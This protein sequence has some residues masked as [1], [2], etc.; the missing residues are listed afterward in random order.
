MQELFLGK[1]I[2][3][4]F[5]VFREGLSSIS[6]L[7]YSVF[8]IWPQQKREGEREVQR[9]KR[10]VEVGRVSLLLCVIN[11]PTRRLS[12]FPALCC[13]REAPRFIIHQDKAYEL[14]M[15]GRV[16]EARWKLWLLACI[17]TFRDGE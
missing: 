6:V 2:R 10:E 5:H 11:H 9:W 7:L 3:E 8:I 16:A 13:H 1:V 12:P 15:S 4:V 14:K 17:I